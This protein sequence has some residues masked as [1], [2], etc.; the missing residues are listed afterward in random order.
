[1][2]FDWIEYLELAKNL[3]ASPGSLGSEEASY[4]SATSRAYYAVLHRASEL[5]QAEG[6][7][8]CGSG[9]DHQGIARHFRESKNGEIRKKIGS[10]LDRMRRSRNQADYDQ[11]LSQSPRAM[12]SLTIKTAERLVKNLETMTPD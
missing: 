2:S 9:D 8:S 4:R 10:D 7:I 1:M 11:R 3:E 6:Y 12:A 5:A